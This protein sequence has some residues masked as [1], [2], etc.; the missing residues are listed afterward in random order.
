M[1]KKLTD[2]GFEVTAKNGKQHMERVVREVKLF[3]DVIEQAKI[4]K[5]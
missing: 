3:K 5:L 4:T 1:K 2:A